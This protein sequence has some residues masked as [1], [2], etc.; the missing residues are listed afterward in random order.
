M[1]PRNLSQ[2]TGTSS[3]PLSLSPYQ[4]SLDQIAAYSFHFLFSCKMIVPVSASGLQEQAAALVHWL[5]QGCAST[6]GF[7]SFST[8]PYDSAWVSMI[9]K[10]GAG[11]VKQWLFPECFQYL[12]KTQNTN[13]GWGS[14]TCVADVDILLNTMVTVLA[15]KRHS[16]EP[17]NCPI[18][19]ELDFRI[20]KAT[21]FLQ[22][23]LENWDIEGS[24]HVGFEILVPS[25]LRMLEEVDSKFKVPGLSMLQSMKDKKLSKFDPRALYGRTRLTM[26]HSLEAFVDIVDFDKVT[27]HLQFGSMMASPAS[28]AAYLM[29]STVWSDEA[30]HYLSTVIAHSSGKGAG[31]VPSA[32]PT[33]I[34]EL[35]W[36]SSFRYD[37][38][39]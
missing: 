32:F 37:Q 1:L 14:D 16:V 12:L 20:S 22:A 24:D 3:L 31:G 5:A 8:V 13:G 35:A 33:P 28:T 11:G 7:G 2:S 18:P 21:A 39:Y 26:L 30:E 38:R 19:V 27:H 23:Q 25:L 29:H 15:L 34:F 4:A 6:S 36:V 9:Q 17:L 10:V